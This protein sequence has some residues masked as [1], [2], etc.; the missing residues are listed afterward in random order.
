MS[1]QLKRLY[2]ESRNLVMFD[3]RWPRAGTALLPDMAVM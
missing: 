1:S 2:S 3:E